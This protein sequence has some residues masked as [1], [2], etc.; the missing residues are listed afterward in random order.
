MKQT[1]KLIIFIAIFLMIFSIFQIPS[2]A[3]NKVI[4]LDPGHGG[5]TPGAINDNVGLV[6]RDINLKIA[7]YLKE[8]LSEY[9]G[10]TVLLTHNGSFDGTYELID[11]AIFARNNNADLL[12]SLHCNSSTSGL[13]TGAEVYVTANTSLPKYNEECS[14]LGNM[15]LNNLNRIGIT[16]NGVKTRLSGDELEVYSDGTRGDYYGIIRY[17]MKGIMDGPGADIQNGEGLSAVLVEHCYMQGGD[18]QFLDS[19]EDI[20]RLAKADCD[21]IV[22]YYGLRLKSECVGSVTLDKEELELVERDKSKLIAT[23]MPDTAINKKIIWTSND[24]TV[25]TV[26]ENGEVTAV[27]KGEAIITATSE[28]GEIKAN[29]NIIVSGIEILRE[30]VY[31]LKDEEYKLE[32][33]ADGI[34]VELKVEDEEIVNLNDEGIITGLKEGTTKVIITS[35]VD[36][37]LSKEIDI[38]VTELKE[39]QVIKINNIK[40]ENG[41]LSKINEKTTKEDFIENFEISSDFEIQIDNNDKEFI[42][43]N[44]IID[45]VDKESKKIIKRYY[46]LIYADINEDGKI[47]AMDYTYIKNHIMDVK[48]INNGISRKIADVSN[49]GRISALDYTLIKNHIMDVKKIEPR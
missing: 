27:S 18:E 19:E 15:I 38:N 44:T 41:S 14:K 42:T 47:S 26:D 33:N 34:D 24:E 9:A 21:A 5:A 46:C 25:A 2:L 49:D 11:R 8:Y 16:N 35:K 45:I 13:L 22:E 36:S 17:A 4:V 20:K 1:I 48:K 3:A 40:V 29:C 10:I 31:L 39:N 12:V 6:E 32:Y 7:N 43:T 37:S 23:V 28:D 30:E